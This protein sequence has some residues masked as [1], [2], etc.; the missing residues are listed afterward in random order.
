M[1]APSKEAEIFKKYITNKKILIVDSSSSAR[2]GMFK[3]LND[4]GVKTSQI[5]LCSSF[6]TAEEEIKASKPEIVLTEYDLGKSCGLELLQSQR[7]SNPES[8]KSIFLLITGNTSQSAVARSA[9]EDIDGYILKPFTPEV[10]RKTIM[11]T[12]IMKIQPP[13]Y[14]VKIDQAKE[15]ME[16]HDFDGAEADLNEAVNL[17]PKPSLALYYLGQIKFLR[18]LLE[19]AE[20]AYKAGLGYNKIHYKCMVGL[21][22]MLMKGQK[23]SDAYEVVKRIS[24]YFP[25]NPK[26]LA[27]V[28]RLAIMNQ[29]Y[30]DV[31]KYYSVFCNI[32]ERSDT[33]IRYICAALV[34]CGKYYLTTSNKTRAME[35]FQ[36]ATATSAGRTNIL[37]E[38]VMTLVEQKQPKEAA[39]FLARFPA[40][41]QSGEE[42]LVLKLLV[43]NLSANASAIIAQGKELISKGIFNES[44][45]EVLIAR[46]KESNSDSMA[47]NLLY[48]AQAKFPQSKKFG[49][50]SNKKAA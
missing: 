35:L 41:T 38:V 43:A 27:E 50:S 25:A 19:K 5:K 16:K 6:H 18:E 32:D 10:L 30:E 1:A 22:E 29:K 20:G 15:K 31:E 21:Y 11:Q 47:E 4:L 7:L 34:V 26:R 13:P 17:D 49:T 44:V 39:E 37:K 9:E 14:N 23:H 24:Q 12:A 28:L 2:T 33:L 8:K 3:I 36:K 45:Y 42:Y 40:N 46:A 48:E